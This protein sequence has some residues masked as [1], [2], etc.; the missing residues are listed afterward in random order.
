MVLGSFNKKNRPARHVGPRKYFCISIEKLHISAYL[1]FFSM[2]SILPFM[3][4]AGGFLFSVV[5]V[6]DV[7]S[8]TVVL[9]RT[10]EGLQKKLGSVRQNPSK[11]EIWGP[12]I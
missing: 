8:P 12:T 5:L 9:C 11:S 1:N 10:S 4:Q 3:S 7:F 2:S 6:E